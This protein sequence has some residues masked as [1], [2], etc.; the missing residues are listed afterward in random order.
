[1]PLKFNIEKPGRGPTNPKW[2]DAYCFTS[3][4]FWNGNRWEPMTF[5]LCEHTIVPSPEGIEILGREGKWASKSIGKENWISNVEAYAKAYQ[6]TLGWF[7]KM[8]KI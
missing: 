3:A 2:I 1:M 6:Q 7:R 8:F 5:N 4:N